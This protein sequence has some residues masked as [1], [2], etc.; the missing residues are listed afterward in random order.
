MWQGQ[1]HRTCRLKIH[2][3]VILELE[4]LTILFF[5][6]LFISNKNTD[7]LTYFRDAVFSLGSRQKPRQL[8][9]TPS[10]SKSCFLSNVSYECCVANS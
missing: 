6:F 2:T 5:S 3:R 7:W 10:F 1:T 9:N 8:E 4:T